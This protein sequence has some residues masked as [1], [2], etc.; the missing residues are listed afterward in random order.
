M[1]GY[2]HLG[3][4]GGDPSSGQAGMLDIV[5]VLEWVRDNIAAFGGDPANVTI[6]GE[7]GG[8]AKV[9]HAAGDAGART[10]SST[11]PIIQSGPG[12]RAVATEAATE[13]A[14]A[15]LGVLGV[16]PGELGKLET[17][18]AA[19]IQDAAAKVAG[20]RAPMARLQP[21]HRRGRPAA[22]PLPPGCAGDL[23][24]RAGDDRHQQG[25]GDALP[26]W[27]PEVRRVH[28]GGPR[29]AGAGRRS[30]TRPPALIAALREALPGLFA[31]A[32]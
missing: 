31:D 3:E 13:N 14:K 16:K 24:R 28:R 10:A 12:L 21:V 5:L 9:S 6:F 22:R 32:T 15:L 7:S 4:L 8:G 20:A 26:A 19:E 1:F 2:L 18:S 27:P 25:R 11:G 23:G 30:A 29:D 17:L